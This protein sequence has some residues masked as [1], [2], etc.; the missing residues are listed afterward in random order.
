MKEW[1]GYYE[2]ILTMNYQKISH[3][4]LWLETIDLFK[5]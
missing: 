4:T 2:N 5:S 1:I 3:L